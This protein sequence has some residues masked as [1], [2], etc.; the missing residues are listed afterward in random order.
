MK[1]MRMELKNLETGQAEGKAELISVKFAGFALILAVLGISPTFK[2]VI[3][4]LLKLMN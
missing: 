4:T 1:D 2:D 3:G